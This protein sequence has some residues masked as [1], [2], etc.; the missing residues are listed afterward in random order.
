ME[1]DA[2]RIHQCLHGYDD[3]H[4]LIQTST[5]IPSKADR[6]LLTLSDMSGPTMVTGF[7]PYLTGYPVP[8]TS[9]Y[10]FAETWYAPEKPRPGCVW[11]HTLL[12]ET[13]DLARIQNWELLLKLFARPSKDR[14]LKSYAE[15]LVLLDTRNDSELCLVDEPRDVILLVLSA[16]YQQSKPVYLAAQDAKTH[17]DLVLTIWNQQYPKLRRSFSFCTASLAN[18][19]ILGRAFD[20]QIIPATSLRDVQ[21][22]VPNGVFIEPEKVTLPLDLP[23][24]IHT[25]AE[26]LVHCTNSDLR[27]FLLLFG[28]D[29]AE[30]REP[31][32]QILD[33]YTK[34]HA[35]E[36]GA[37]RLFEIIEQISMYYPGAQQGARLKQVLLGGNSASS[38]VA[39]T[40]SESDLLKE[41]AVTDR[42]SAFD[43]DS[44]RLRE[45]ASELVHKQPGQFRQLILDLLNYDLNPLGEQIIAGMAEAVTP[46]IALDV[47]RQKA[48]LLFV[49]TK[50]NP[51]LL[52]AP[53]IWQEPKDRQRELLDFVQP[54][55][56]SGELSIAKVMYAMLTAG[57]DVLAE[58]LIRQYGSVAVAAVLDWFENYPSSVLS[59][60]WER[61]LA[62]KPG[63]ILDWLDTC[64]EP[65]YETM[66]LL[67]SLLDPHSASVLKFGT[68]VWLPLARSDESDMGGKTRI[69]VM[70]FLLALG[71]S[72]PDA[73][74]PQLV[75]EA[76]QP[77]HDAAAAE[78]LPYASW[79]LLMYQAPSLTWWGEWDKCERLRRALVDKFI[80]FKWNHEFFLR[81]IR[82]ADT[83][84]EVIRNCSGQKR[85]FRVI[86]SEIDNGYLSASEEQRVL[87]GSV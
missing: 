78:R 7:Q 4:Q 8:D 23:P 55:L 10:A 77:V 24:W 43:A 1:S 29:A 56:E 40:F 3:G 48:G 11:T 31:F 9:W 26:D 54:Q 15:P 30:G 33:L 74:A 58:D 46:T 83:L 27:Q 59:E 69:S 72:N 81:A 28:A 87:L 36:S 42:S 86:S 66:A 45:R 75:A 35:I 68:N 70:A 41:L 19:K 52:T 25:A 80:R 53:E 2:I 67:T 32:A 34:V 39:L 47:G 71:F 62:S 63:A 5:R 57:S 17:Q 50:Y 21:R 49:L 51:A 65:R 44:L 16:L 6:L 82:R 85:F 37:P 60:N 14:K 13:A 38:R 64:G 12:I 79:R 22:D 73:H 61:A 76:F 84:R 18:R 20:L